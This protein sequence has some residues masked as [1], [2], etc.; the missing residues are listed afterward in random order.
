MMNS[1]PSRAPASVLWAVA[2]TTG[3]EGLRAGAGTFRVL[4][5]LP[6]RAAV[7][8]VAFAAFSR[9]TDLSTAGVAFYAAYGL[10]GALL[11]G[12]TW[13]VAARARAPRVLRR[14]AAVAAVSSLLVL[15]LTTQAAP[16][17]WK[18]GSSPSD[19]ALLA[20]LLDRFTRLTILRV[21][22]VDVS[23]LAMLSAL[24]ITALRAQE[25]R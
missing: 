1:V 12:A 21:A 10:G 25:S 11:T 2:V 22:C 23:F 8:P 20:D 17:M 14:L 5:D 3:F 15:A 6:A 7:G 9:A 19:P 18:V 4:L 16:V 24:A 13:I